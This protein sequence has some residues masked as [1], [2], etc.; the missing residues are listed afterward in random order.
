MTF[1][2]KRKSKILTTKLQTGE[3]FKLVGIPHKFEF[4]YI[5]ITGMAVSKS[6]RALNDWMKRKHRRKNVMKLNTIPPKKRN[7]KTFW[8]A[9][10]V[11]KQWM[12]EIPEGDA[13]TL[14]CEGVNADQLFRIYTKWFE[15]HENIPW[16]ISEEHK[17][18][19]FYKKRT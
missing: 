10:N 1:K 2:V 3:V 12:K 5:W 9:V 16:V 18:F 13:L 19:F 15:K 17:S 11:I 7:Y 6:T 4:G 8:I 14:R